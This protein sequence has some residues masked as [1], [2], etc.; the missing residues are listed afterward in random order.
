MVE[1]YKGRRGG[2]DKTMAPRRDSKRYF[3]STRIPYSE[4]PK[5]RSF[6]TEYPANKIPEGILSRLRLQKIR[7]RR[8]KRKMYV[9]S[10]KD[11]SEL[12]SA[13]FMLAGI[14][15]F[16][17]NMTGSIVQNYSTTNAGFVGT[18]LFIFG[19]VGLMISLGR[20]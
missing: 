9:D 6:F 13:I 10:G 12:L 11:I 18:I 1:D 17:P 7:L 5:G 4:S 15:L 20:K 19:V 14:F 16:L 2:A 3:A 8:D